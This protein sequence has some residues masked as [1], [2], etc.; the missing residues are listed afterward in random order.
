M[1]DLVVRGVRHHV[2]RLGA[3][4]PPVVFV[5]GLVMDN[6]SSW[7]FSVANA[8]ATHRECILY[9]LRGHG[10]SERT[11]DGYSLDGL[12]ADLEALIETLEL[13][14]VHL[15]GNSFGGLLALVTALQSPD[16]VKSLVL[17]DGLLPE[18]G[19]GASMVG[20]LGLTGEAA[21]SRI[22]ESFRH[23]LGR[24][25]ERKRNRLARQAQA[26][27]EGS[28][29]LAD[30]RGSR[31][32][33]DEAYEGLSCPVLALYGAQ[34]DQRDRGE[35]LA[36]RHPGVELELL[37]GCTHSILWEQTARVRERIVQ[38]VSR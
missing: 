27:V 28:T 20:T 21:E 38:W 8:V 19:W 35:R 10:L 31:E 9:D 11:E 26:L 29:L 1:A 22:A 23:W 6:L 32:L 34:S 25:S 37:D 12:A 15:V 17:V 33:P 36:R 14:P 4:S 18:P 7:Y 13:P 24:H 5:H 30:I 3:G 16:R 2:Q